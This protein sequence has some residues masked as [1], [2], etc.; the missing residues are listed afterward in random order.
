MRVH[1]DAQGGMEQDNE[2]FHHVTQ[3]RSILKFMNCLF[4]ELKK[5][6]S[7]VQLTVGNRNHEGGSPIL[8]ADSF[9]SEP[10]GKAMDKE[11]YCISAYI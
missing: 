6:C 8:Q 9:P 2:W 11:Y 4:L 1:V 3:N 10:S 7:G 5:K